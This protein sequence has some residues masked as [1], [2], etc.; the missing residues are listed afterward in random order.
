MSN[1]RVSDRVS[2]SLSAAKNIMEDTVLLAQHQEEIK[3]LKQKNERLGARLCEKDK[4]LREARKPVDRH[5]HLKDF[6][7]EYITEKVSRTEKD[8]DKIAQK[9]KEEANSVK[10]KMSELARNDPQ[11]E[12]WKA[13]EDADDQKFLDD[14]KQFEA[15]HLEE[16][17]QLGKR[18]RDQHAEALGSDIGVVIQHARYDLEDSDDDEAGERASK[19][20]KAA[21][22]KAGKEAEKPKPKPKED[23]EPH[24]G[25]LGIKAPVRPKGGKAAAASASVSRPKGGKAAAKPDAKPK[26]KAAAA[27]KGVTKPSGPK[28]KKEPKGPRT[29]Y[30]IWMGHEDTK[31]RYAQELEEVKARGDADEMEAFPQPIKKWYSGAWKEVT[32]E[33]VDRFKDLAKKEEEEW[34][35]KGWVR[36]PKATKTVASTKKKPAKKDEEAEEGSESEDDGEAEM[37]GEEESEDEAE[38]MDEGSDNDDE[39]AAKAAVSGDDKP[40]PSSKKKEEPKPEAPKPADREEDSDASNGESDDDCAGD[41]K[42]G[43]QKEPEDEDGNDSDS[44]SHSPSE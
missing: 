10:Q 30:A 19:Q 39:A 36:P 18:L 1:M 42:K 44:S 38:A 13:N 4:R 29:H 23:A 7:V 8:K 21:P 27:S 26:P 9:V 15:V 14:E 20:A 22:K 34:A 12:K 40:G 43:E 16:S 24:P 31:A 35:A 5:R 6:M 17:V 28:G 33:E 25:T 11:T 3:H 2:Q 32:K 37:E 41:D